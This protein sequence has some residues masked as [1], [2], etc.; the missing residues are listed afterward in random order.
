MQADTRK[1]GCARIAVLKGMTS[2]L[3]SV[4]A[5][6]QNYKLIFWSVDPF[7]S[8][9]GITG[10]CF[11]Q[12]LLSRKPKASGFSLKINK[13]QRKKWKR[14]KNLCDAAKKQQYLK[15][16]YFRCML[17]F[18]SAHIEK[19]MIRYYFLLNFFLGKGR[20]ASWRRLLISF[21][22]VR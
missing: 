19:K 13:K 1:E 18:F 3:N 4:S 10:T 11:L 12:S 5:A 6:G 14:Q 7:F 9:A 8:G 17:E 20:Q 22:D 21:L 15:T 2:T 16:V